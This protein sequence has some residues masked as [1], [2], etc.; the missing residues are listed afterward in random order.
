MR[1]YVLLHDRRSK[2][3]TRLP[4]ECEYEDMLEASSP[5]F[6][7]PDFDKNTRATTFHTTGTTGRPKGVYFS[8]RQSCCTRSAS[9]RNTVPPQQ[10][11]INREEVYM[12]LTPMFHVHAWGSPY[13]YTMMG[14]KQVY[15]GRYAP[16]VLL[17]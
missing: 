8:H 15:P 6:Q 7:F 12:P 13:V 3:T 2:P 11:R 10:G 16:D 9:P 17:G 5:F 1:K 14:N 4:I